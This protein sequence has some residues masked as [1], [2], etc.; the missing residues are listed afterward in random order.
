MCIAI[1][2]VYIIIYHTI[3]VEKNNFLDYLK[4]LLS[5]GHMIEY[6]TACVLYNM[7][8]LTNAAAAIYNKHSNYWQ[9]K[10]NSF[11]AV[12]YTNLLWL[13]HLVA[14]G[15]TSRNASALE[16]LCVQKC[17][18]LSSMMRHYV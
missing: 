16:I 2:P 9:W 8:N 3:F 10:D 15:I 7:Y 5:D 17:I 14:K 13:F 6:A 11:F 1:H 4:H 12:K 18:L